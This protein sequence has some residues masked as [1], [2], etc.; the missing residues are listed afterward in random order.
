IGYLIGYLPWLLLFI[1]ILPRR[2]AQTVSADSTRA[3]L[4]AMLALGLFA[5][6]DQ[7]S[8]LVQRS[9]LSWFEPGI[10]SAF[11]YGSRF[12]GLPI[13]ILIGALGIVLFPRL[14]RESVSGNRYG[15]ANVVYV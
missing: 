10:L 2:S 13:S 3:V 14:A 8:S 7:V 12:A 15:S 5:A 11:A 9:V 1:S 4:G 6:F